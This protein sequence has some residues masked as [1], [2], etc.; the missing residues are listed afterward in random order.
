MQAL[1]QE[2]GAALPTYGS[3]G[4]IQELK[5]TDDIA[6]VT[7]KVPGTSLRLLFS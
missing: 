6:A 5:D 7:I 3:N 4:V 1:Q 2:D